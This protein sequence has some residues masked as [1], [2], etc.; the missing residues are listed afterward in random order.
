MMETN[1]IIE[2]LCINF[3][4]KKVKNINLRIHKCGSIKAS[5]PFYLSD[6]DI[7]NF[8]R[9]RLSW[10]RKHQLFILRNKQ[11]I[12]LSENIQIHKLEMQKVVLIL[13]DK[14]QKVIGVSANICRIK[15]MHTRWG[16]C[17]PRK[18]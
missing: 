13:L 8:L 5:V 18:K 7:F 4:R 2:D 16:S 9:S 10:I 3:T 15:L 11:D 1:I 17:N 6:Q 14:W 12:F